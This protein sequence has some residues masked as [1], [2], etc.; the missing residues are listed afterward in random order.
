MYASWHTL[1]CSEARKASKS[2]SVLADKIS[3]EHHFDAVGNTLL[4]KPADMFNVG[5]IFLWYNEANRSP[6]YHRI[7][8]DC[9]AP[10][11]SGLAQ[12]QEVSELNH[13]TGS[14]VCSDQVTQG[15]IPQRFQDSHQI[16]GPVS[17]AWLFLWKK[18]FPQY[19]LRLYSW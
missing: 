13:C 15:F 8:Q 19:F 10:G 11:L 9:S 2:T 12:S 1:A 16:P 18:S 5:R 4:N 7:V 3:R 6:Q 14:A 17:T